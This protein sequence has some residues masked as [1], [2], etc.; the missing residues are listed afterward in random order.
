M[1][2][3][4]FM[5]EYDDYQAGAK[6]LVGSSYYPDRTHSVS[7]GIG[8]SSPGSFFADLGAVLTSYPDTVF[9]PYLYYDSYDAAGNLQN[10]ASPTILNHVNLWNV[11][12]TIGWR[13]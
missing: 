10:V 13:F 12:L 9:V 4:D 11:A 2:A 5:A 3:G 1:T 6:F 7:F 8:Y